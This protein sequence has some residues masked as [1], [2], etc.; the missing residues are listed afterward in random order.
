MGGTKVGRVGV[1]E[2]LVGYLKYAHIIMT[3]QRGTV[4]IT[5]IL[6]GEDI[7]FEVT[8]GL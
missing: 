5:D 2:L 1:H 6:H 4:G 3:Q 7:S 8:P